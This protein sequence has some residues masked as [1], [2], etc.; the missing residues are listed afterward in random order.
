[1]NQ[2]QTSRPPMGGGPMGHG[3]R[4]MMIP[5]AKARD[6]KGTLQKTIRF[7]RSSVPVILLAFV[8][9][10]GSVIL[11][12][13]I[14]KV[15]GN[16]TDEIMVGL[17][18]RNVYDTIMDTQE[19]MEQLG[20]ALAAIPPQRMAALAQDENATLGT[21]MEQGLLPED[22]L[23][24]LDESL[25]QTLSALPLSQ[26]SQMEK[27]GQN[28]S[29]ATIGD[30]LA[31]MEDGQSI[32][33]NI[34]PQYQDELLTT[35]LQSRPGID[36]EAVGHIIMVLI[37]LI[38]LGAILGYLQNFLMSG[39]AQKVSYQL[40]DQINKKMNRLPLS[41]Y[42]KTT[43]G[44]TLSLISND[45]D[46]V[47]TTLNQ[48]L[49]QMITAITTLLGVLVMMFSISGWMTLTSLITL[50]LSFLIISLVVRRSQRHFRAQQEYLGH[51]N[52]HIEE[53]YSGHNVVRLFNGEERSRETFHQMNKKLYAAGWRSQ[54]LS[55]MMQPVLSFVSNLGYVAVC[56]LGGY[57]TIQGRIT[58]G[59]I[60]SFIQ[61]VRRFNQPVM[62]SAQIM[63]TLQSTVAA[64]ERVFTFLEQP[65]EADDGKAK[66]PAE[67]VRG[68]VTFDHV[69]FGYTPEKTIIHDFSTHVKDGQRIAIVGP[70][71]AGKT[72][73]VKLLMHFYELNSGRIL[74]DGVDI[75]DLPRGVLRSQIG[76]VLQDTW[77]F[78]GTIR[79][80]IRYGRLDATDEEVEKAARMA[81][82]D[83]FIRT[84]PGGYDFVLNE[85][86]S[87]VSHGQKQLLTIARAILADP[88]VLILD[89]AT[90]SVDTRTEVLIQQAMNRLMQGRTSFIIAH[91]LSTIRD[92]DR[93]LVLREGD[94]V[95]Q[96]TH[97]ELL[98]KGGFYAN[99]YNSQ[100]EP[101][102][103]AV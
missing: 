11:T 64:A 71:G 47:S 19:A 57:L 51:V 56:V 54:F 92:A 43:H 30:Y 8:L 4:G 58:I 32:I 83:H 7:M 61:Y 27:G 16:A 68:D 95:E 67:G 60:Q 10:I 73:I 75:K 17:M 29:F 48:S 96:G 52:G 2:N 62:Q 72:T 34:P 78:N 59:D 15:L 13:N 101:T 28:T 42:D 84:L 44:E 39:V 23:Q 100:F 5:G 97:E 49:T 22:A 66:L 69:D 53:M 94:I 14:P 85:E 81:C 41:F 70:T 40:R 35:S 80:N 6:F 87:N 3:P 24:G 63:N 90:S 82:A 31:S 25:R 33:E 21:L 79:D 93:I 45:V 38:L 88:A 46:T 20:K 74:L 102:E 50:P 89:E 99:L 9:A 12:L 36:Q 103:E 98:E 86:A 26:M 91:R 55:G 65:E 76:M 18:K 37:V 1:M 77:L